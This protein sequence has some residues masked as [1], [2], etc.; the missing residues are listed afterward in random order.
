[1]SWKRLNRKSALRIN[2]PWSSIVRVYHFFKR[3]KGKQWLKIYK[4]IILH[5]S[6]M[7][8]LILLCQYQSFDLGGSW[9]RLFLYERKSWEWKGRNFQ[10]L[11]QKSGW[12]LRCNAWSSTGGRSFI[13]NSIGEDKHGWKSFGKMLG[14]FK[15]N[16]EYKSGSL[17]QSCPT[18]LWSSKTKVRREALQR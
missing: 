14:D 9:R 10:I 17:P 15:D 8:K 6:S 2:G 11:N 13:H 12:V 3:E 18:L 5:T 4:F 16:H 1:M 7:L